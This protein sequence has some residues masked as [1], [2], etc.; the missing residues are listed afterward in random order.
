MFVFKVTLLFVYS[1]IQT[2]ISARES[3]ADILPHN[4]DV[5]N[6]SVFGN[7]YEENNTASIHGKA[8]VILYTPLCHIS[9]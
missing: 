7:L 2:A 6:G 1:L 9:A 8:S 3:C 5:V 4:S